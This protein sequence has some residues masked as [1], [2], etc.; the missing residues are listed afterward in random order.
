MTPPE[1]TRRALV[2]EWLRKADEDFAVAEYRTEC[3]KCG[4]PETELTSGKELEFA[5]M[6]IDET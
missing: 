1:G 3:P 5:Y 6:E 4:S 2:D